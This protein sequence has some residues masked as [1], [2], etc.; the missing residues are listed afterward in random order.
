MKISTMSLVL[1]CGLL[2]WAPPGFAQQRFSMQLSQTQTGDFDGKW[3]GSGRRDP[4]LSRNRCGD[5]PIIELTV[6]AGKVAAIFKLS[7]RK[8]GQTT[9]NIEVIPLSGSVDDQGNMALVGSQSTA[10]GLLS[11]EDGSGKGTWEFK[12]IACRGSYQVRKG[13]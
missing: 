8:A 7:L 1:V 13:P 12:A 2:L 9:P 4:S 6:Q 5:G 11:A 3:V 10:V